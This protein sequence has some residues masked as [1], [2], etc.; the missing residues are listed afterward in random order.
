MAITNHDELKTAV[1][2]FMLDDSSLATPFD[3][4]L[5]LAEQAIFQ[6]LFPDGAAPSEMPPLRVQEMETV[7]TITITTGSGSLPAD[8]LQWRRVVEIVSPRRPLEWL[9]PNAADELYPSRTSGLANHF[10]IIGTTIRPFPVTSNN[11]EMTYFGQ[12]ATLVGGGTTTSAFLSKY[13]GIYLA[14]C[15]AFA[16]HW[17]R[18]V[19]EMQRQ[20]SLMKALIAGANRVFDRTQTANMGMTFGKR[21]VA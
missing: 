19:E 9:P 1:Q 8:Y 20:L 13:S 21:R 17:K 16:A 12:P 4:F 7:A 15:S 5:T 6:G 11:L 3:N 18:D 10:T 14:G 2:D